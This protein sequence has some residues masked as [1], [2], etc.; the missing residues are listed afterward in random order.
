[1]LPDRRCHGLL[2]PCTYCLAAAGEAAH[3]ADHGVAAVADSGVTP[4]CLRTRSGCVPVLDVVRREPPAHQL[5][6]LPP[7][8]QG[9]D[10]LHPQTPL[11]QRQPPQLLLLHAP[12]CWRTSR[13]RSCCC[14][15]A[16]GWPW[17][18]PGAVRACCPAA[19]GQGA[20]QVRLPAQ[21]AHLHSSHDEACVSV[22]ASSAVLVTR[23]KMR[24]LVM[25][26]SA[27]H[28][29]HSAESISGVKCAC[30]GQVPWPIITCR[31]WACITCQPLGQASGTQQHIAQQSPTSHSPDA[32]K[33]SNC[34]GAGGPVRSW[35]SRFCTW[36]TVVAFNK[37]LV[38][39]NWQHVEASLCCT[40]A[41][42][43]LQTQASCQAAAR[44]A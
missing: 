30:R 18:S 26:V 2:N 25:H 38:I 28:L 20:P 36:A 12:P 44:H 5:L 34:T 6:L 3:V 21:H 27:P 33:G 19:W 32:M 14:C 17:W 40:H 42:C 31:A 13:G 4:P 1:M 22:E 9:P 41:Q 39:A 8:P 7:Q 16:V 43:R 24:W 11:Q 37:M 15:V 23:Q 35:C 10:P 29:L